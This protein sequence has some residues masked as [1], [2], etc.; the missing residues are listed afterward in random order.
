ME[1]RRTI[2]LCLQGTHRAFT[3]FREAAGKVLSKALWYLLLRVRRVS[4][5]CLQI[6]LG[7]SGGFAETGSGTA[8][9]PWL[10]E[11]G[12]CLSVYGWVELV[13][14]LRPC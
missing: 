3:G 6:P 10:A 11:G 5:V 13:S 8:T 14:L 1:E 4:R 9:I 12:G 2:G 7:A